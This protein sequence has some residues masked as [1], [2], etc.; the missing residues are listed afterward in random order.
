MLGFRPA[1]RRHRLL[2]RVAIGAIAASA[3]V[4][5]IFLLLPEPPQYVPGA[6]VEGLTSEL[7]RDL[8]TTAPAVTFVDASREAGILFRHFHGRRSHQLPEDMGSGAAWADVEG[9]GDLALFVVNE[10]GP[11]TDREAWADSPAHNSLFINSG[12]GRFADGAEAAGLDRRASGQG[13]AFG[14]RDG[15]GDVDLALSEYG[16]LL[17]YDND[18]TGVFSEIGAPVG[19]AGER[20][21]TGLTWADSD[22]DGDLDLYACAYVNYNEDPALRS[23][24]S[25]QYDTAIPA[26]LNPS[27]FAPQAN[28][29]WRNDGDRFTDVA[30]VAGVDNPAGRSLSATFADFDEDGQLDLYVANDLSDNVLYHN[31][32]GTFADVSHAAWVADYR[33]AMGLA[34]GDWDNDGDEDLFI[35]HWIAQENALFSNM[36]G[37]F[38]EAGVAGQLRFMDTADQFGLGQIALDY[39]GWGT[40]FMDYDADGR[41]DLLVANGSTFEDSESPDQLVPMRDLLFWN[42]GV[43]QGF[44]EVGEV[45]G[46]AMRQATVSRGLAVADYDGDGD[47]DAFINVNGG[48]GLLLRHEGHEHHWLTV[49]AQADERIHWLGTRIRIVA[50]AHSWVRQ[51][52]TGSSYLSQNALGEEYFGLGESGIADIVEISWPDGT[53]RHWLNVGADRRLQVSRSGPLPS[54]A[55]QPE[56]PGKKPRLS[57]RQTLDFWRIYQQATRL[58]VAGDIVGALA[59]YDS[60]LALDPDHGDALYHSGGATFELGDFASAERRWQRL[61]SV[62]SSNARAHVQ[63]GLLYSCGR[64]GAP[65]NLNKARKALHRALSLNRAETGPQVRLGEIALLQQD[66]ETAG[67]HLDAARRTNERSISGHYLVGYLHWRAGRGA[68]AEAALQEAIFAA[69]GGRKEVSGSAEGQTKLGAVPLQRGYVGLLEPL[70]RPALEDFGSV[71]AAGLQVEYADFEQA[72]DSLR[73]QRAAR[74]Q[75]RDGDE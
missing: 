66:W 42:G 25:Q 12:E 31:A 62:D 13:A 2:L 63:L 6:P 58:R 16:P 75:L 8:P 18:G 51:A 32:G 14:D 9:D 53:R 17:L 71:S 67:K 65:Y 5:G 20:F 59:H 35:T 33:G 46:D 4:A 36:S 48:N 68:A 39:V 27:T 43:P 40:A 54:Q 29:L 34:A 28:A 50:G 72:M 41:L 21:W 30:V 61:L 64:Q 57:R 22:G 19:V 60:A 1:R 15:D 49:A 73:T 26:S 52:G 69:A 10:A 47:T 44:Y 70:W 38:R 7:S 74:E 23:T 3:A 11:L 55:R 56:P 37:D 45:S 24:A